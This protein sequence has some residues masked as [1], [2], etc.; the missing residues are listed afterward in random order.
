[1]PLSPHRPTLAA[2]LVAV[3]AI[4]A[5]V[6]LAQRVTATTP[7]NAI[8]ERA[9]RDLGSWQ[10]ECWQWMKKVV[11]EATGQ[12]IGFDYR[13]GYFEAGALEVS[14]AEAAPGDIV[15]IALDSWTSPDAD[16][17]GLH[18]AIIL[19]VNGDGTFDVIDSNQQWDGIV[20]LRPG[21][22]PVALA[23]TR[24]LNFHIY[25][26]TAGAT[27]AATARAPQPAPAP[28]ISFQ[29]GDRARVNTPGE[30]LNL[31]SEPVGNVMACV[32]HGTS[33]TVIGSPVTA[34]GMTWVQVQT[35]N[36]AGWMAAPYLQKEPSAA[37][38]PS[39]AGGVSPVFQY[40]A[41]IPLTSSD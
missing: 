16:Y 3:V 28:A 24:G 30:C 36:G 4:I 29:A 32:P 12:S 17:A 41:F 26:I 39:G 5:A 1:M 7:S 40:R 2:I 33:A 35:P 31:R 25:R 27:P 15:Q 8:A 10:G 11:A 14:I 37:A 23:S 19:E 20:R 6:G 9:L 21:Y 38:S 18:T 22:D 34:A 13:D